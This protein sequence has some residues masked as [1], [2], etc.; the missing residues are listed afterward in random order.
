MAL[1]ADVSLLSVLLIISEI[2]AKSAYTANLS[3]D[4]M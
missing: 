1:F 2:K 3:N 4:K